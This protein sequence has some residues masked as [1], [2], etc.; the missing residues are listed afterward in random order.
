MKEVAGPAPS[1]SAPEDPRAPGGRH[2]QP[3]RRA[4]GREKAGPGVWLRS[5]G[6]ALAGF[7]PSAASSTRSAQ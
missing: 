4:S 7:G 1:D 3:R 2:L 6:R 5:P